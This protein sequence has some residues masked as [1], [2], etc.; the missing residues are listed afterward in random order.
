M[1]TAGAVP[2]RGTTQSAPGRLRASCP[3]ALRPVCEVLRWTGDRKERIIPFGP[4]IQE[5]WPEVEKPRRKALASAAVKR[6]EASASR[7][8]RPSPEA[9]CDGDIRY[10]AKP[11]GT[12]APTRR[13]A[14]LHFL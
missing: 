11:H 13:S 14:S 6:R 2:A 12:V 3:P 8:A 1:R 7:G 4:A 9:Q 5:T 10:V